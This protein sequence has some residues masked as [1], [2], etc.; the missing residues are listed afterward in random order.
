MSKAVYTGSFDPIH[1]GHIDIIKRAA[2]LFDEVT[3]AVSINLAKNTMYDFD[4]RVEMIKAA[5][6]NIP[7]IKVD[8]CTGLRA[9][10]INDNKFDVEVKS[11]RNS[12]DF[13]YEL[14]I[15]QMHAKLFDNTE[16]V[17]L[18]TD[19][20]YSYISSTQVRQVFSLGGDVSM[21]VHPTTLEIMQNKKGK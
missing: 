11:L 5:C 8:S 13:E 14:P 4:T 1:L 12:A 6:K 2:Q 7:N 3:V 10:Y 18:M 19:P 9:K 20:E 16:T 21:M 17:F 15:S